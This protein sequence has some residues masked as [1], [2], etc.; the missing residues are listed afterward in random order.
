MD[1]GSDDSDCKRFGR[2]DPKKRFADLGYTAFSSSPEDFAKFVDM[3]TEKWAKV[4]Q[5]S[6]AKAE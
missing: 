3:E 1:R 2:C 6:G 5:F 4:I